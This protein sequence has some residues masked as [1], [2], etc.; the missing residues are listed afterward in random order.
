ME[1]HSSQVVRHEVALRIRWMVAVPS[2]QR[3]RHAQAACTRGTH[4]AGSSAPRMA[5]PATR[6]PVRAVLGKLAARRD[7]VASASSPSTLAAS[8]HRRAS[9]AHTSRRTPSLRYIPTWRRPGLRR[10]GQDQRRADGVMHRWARR[11]PDAPHQ[12]RGHGT[13]PGPA[14]GRLLWLDG[15]FELGHLDVRRG[16]GDRRDRL[17]RPRG[18]CQGA[19]R[20]SRASRRS[21][22]WSP[23]WARTRPRSRH[24]A[25]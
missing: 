1:A 12:H 8:A 25:G 6:V 7:P 10:H 17:D 15:R 2:Y 5:R 21:W 23:P 3:S 24:Q 14:R 18:H 11:R 9:T 19:A 20:W 4:G 22:R 16:C 13:R